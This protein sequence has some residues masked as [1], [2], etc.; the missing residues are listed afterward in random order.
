MS[1]HIYSSGRG[2]YGV[3]KEG[4]EKHCYNPQP[5]LYWTELEMVPNLKGINTGTKDKELQRYSHAEMLGLTATREFL[6][7]IPTTPY[8]EAVPTCKKRWKGI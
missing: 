8:T 5:F 7:A 2:N 4:E 6:Q 3:L 1:T